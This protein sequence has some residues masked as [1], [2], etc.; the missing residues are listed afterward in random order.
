LVMSSVGNITS[1]VVTVTDDPKLGPLQNN[2][3]L[4]FTM[5]PAVTSPV[6]GAGNPDLAP[7]TDQRGVTRPSG[8][9][10]DLGSVQVT[11]QGFNPTDTASLI[12]ALQAASDAPG[13]TTIINLQAGTT[14]TLTDVNNFWYGPDSLPPIDSN[15]IIHGNGATIARDT[16]AA[17]NTPAF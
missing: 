13:T 4:T 3:G 8:G 1:G 5:L 15:V 12:A 17:D 16:N 11:T 9:P 2:G 10:T 14:Y 6:L 7:E